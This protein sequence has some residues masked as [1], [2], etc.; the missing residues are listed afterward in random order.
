MWDAYVATYIVQ[1]H[2]ALF[3]TTFDRDQLC[4]DAVCLGLIAVVHTV[5]LLNMCEVHL[6]SRNSMRTG[7]VLFEQFNLRIVVGDGIKV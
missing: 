5:H 2:G 7:N 4:N 1:Q 3:G 6:I